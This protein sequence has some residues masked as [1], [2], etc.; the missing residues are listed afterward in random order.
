MKRRLTNMIGQLQEDVYKDFYKSLEKEHL[1]DFARLLEYNRQEDVS[2]TTVMNALDIDSGTYGKMKVDLYEK[3]QDHLLSRSDNPKLDLI[4]KVSTVPHLIYNTDKD[5]ARAILAKLEKDLIAFDLPYQ[6][7]TV[8][9]AMKKLNVNSEKY[10]ENS[11]Q[12]NKH[13]AQTLALD[14]AEDMLSD[15]FKKL[16]E[17]IVSRDDEII[18]I[19]KLIKS[20]MSETSALYESHHL[21]IFKGIVDIAYALYVPESESTAEDDAIEDIVKSARYIFKANSADP[22]YQ[23]L[24]LV[25][26]FLS[27]EYY[28]KLKIYKK[29]DE[30]FEE[31]NKN[32]RPFLQYNYYTYPAK[33]LISKLERY[34]RMDKEDK[35]YKENQN[36]L[37]YY[38][39][40]KEDLGNHILYK[41][42]LAACCYYKEK[43]QEA[44]QHLHDLENDAVLDQCKHASIE[45][46]LL[47][48][49]C[50]L[51][52]NVPDQARICADKAAKDIKQASNINY[53]NAR[54]FLNMIKGKNLDKK[55]LFTL[56]DNFLLLN[57]GPQQLLQ[58]IKMEDKF[59]DHL[60]SL[61]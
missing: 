53:E 16:G 58:Y 40:S 47:L 12:Y 21:T 52:S 3:I 25:Y 37:K 60:S 27:F 7:T 48:S 15:F 61:G 50:Y 33:F 34:V 14:K 39:P 11:Q 49:I 20:K 56:R 59:I 22:A 13:V 57:Q 26:H 45:V 38:N 17:Y 43:Y 51:F 6:L 23:Y 44:I 5:I 2:E 8:Y 28:H 41:Q 30:P 36:L 54:Q 4:H 29:E 55:K 32:L 9:S 1:F 19:L 18:E 31:V 35:L 46:N 10:Y 24:N 42:Y